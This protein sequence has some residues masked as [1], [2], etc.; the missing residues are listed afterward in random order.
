[1]GEVQCCGNHLLIH[2][3]LFMNPGHKA[4]MVCC[5]SNFS[6]AMKAQVYVFMILRSRF[7]IKSTPSSLGVSSLGFL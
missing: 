1:M 4:V 3:L 6:A 2:T 5:V 7:V